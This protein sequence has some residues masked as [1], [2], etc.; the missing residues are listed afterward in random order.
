MTYPRDAE[1]LDPDAEGLPSVADD[2]STAYDEPESRMRDDTAPALPG[3]EPLGVDSYGVTAQEEQHGEPLK[4][5]LL[6]EEPEL[7]SRDIDDTID[8]I[9]LNEPS[10]RQIGRLEDAEAQS[11]AYDTGETL[12]LSAEE[13]AMHE[14][15]EEQEEGDDL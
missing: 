14:V 10:P 1:R 12:G 6:R 9:D 7:H 4:A 5:R 3:D 8:S 13:A 15:R 2:T 11:V